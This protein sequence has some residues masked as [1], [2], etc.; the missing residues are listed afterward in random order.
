[1]CKQYSSYWYLL[2]AILLTCAPLNGYFFS[3]GVVWR[4]A[5]PLPIAVSRK[6]CNQ[7]SMC[8]CDHGRQDV[9]TWPPWASMHQDYC[10]GEMHALKVDNTHF[11]HLPTR[12]RILCLPRSK[13]AHWHM[14]TIQEK[15]AYLAR[16]KLENK[17][18]NPLLHCSHFHRSPCVAF[19]GLFIYRLKH[20]CNRNLGGLKLPRRWTS[21][22]IWPGSECHA[23]LIWQWPNLDALKVGAWKGRLPTLRIRICIDLLY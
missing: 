20:A 8:L 6:K 5:H 17:L 3:W 7:V 23:W 9:S 22:R 12:A 2:S 18:N 1:M 13:Q 10:G 16:M 11:C 14:I 19:T 4:L 21:M 15:M